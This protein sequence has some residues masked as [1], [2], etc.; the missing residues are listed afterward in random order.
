MGWDLGF[1]ISNQLLGHVGLLV[2]GHTLRS[3]GLKNARCIPLLGIYPDKTF[4]RKDTR[5]RM[6]TAAPFTI[7]KTWKPPKC[8]P[9]DEWIKRCSI[10]APVVAQWLRNL[11]STHEDAGLFHILAQWVK[12]LA[13]RKMKFGSCLAVAVV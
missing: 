10:G 11:T 3:K 13:L 7:A 2:T 1:C 12:D 5:I 4:I 8:P 6:F 9:I